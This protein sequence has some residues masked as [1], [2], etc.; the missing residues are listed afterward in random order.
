MF[1]REIFKGRLNFWAFAGTI[2]LVI[3]GYIL[4]QLPIS[5]A[6]SIYA[7]KSG[8]S[9][10]DLEKVQ[11]TMDFS[12][13]GIDQNLSLALI[14]FTFIFAL[15]GLYIGIRTLHK[16]SFVS[17]LNACGKVRWERIFYAFF[18]WVGITLV[19]EGFFYWFNPEDYRFNFR[20]GPFFELFLIAVFMLPFQ[21]SVEEFFTRGYL[22]QLFGYLFKIPWVSAALTAML[23]A[24]MHG[25]NPEVDK[26]GTW[27]MMS[28]YFSVGLFLAVMTVLDDGLELALG[29]H[30]AT[31]I[32]GALFATYKGA[33]IQTPA[34]FELVHPNVDGMV[35]EFLIAAGIFLIVAQKKF[36]P[37]NWKK[38]I[39][40]IE[41]SSYGNIHT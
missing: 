2:I 14:I 1:F 8:S 5:L 38:L 6:A 10:E 7:A 29:I 35:L 32:F 40:T 3:L 31:N 18:I 21:T 24:L 17:I 19:A 4:G 30:A 26:F 20:A 36:G 23:F 41:D 25:M 16:R 15:I 9:V 28:Y 37:W 13:L 34:L 12:I 22:L 39:A 27:T 11:E 33:V